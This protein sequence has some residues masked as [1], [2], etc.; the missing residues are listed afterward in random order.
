MQQHKCRT[1]PFGGEEA[2]ALPPER[3][4]EIMRYLV[5]LESSHLCHSSNNTLICRGGR[6]IQLRVLTALKL[7]K[8]PTDEEFDRVS[9]EV[10][11]EKF[12]ND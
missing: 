9:R 5:N 10:L 1:C 6:E 11:G 2:I 7:L 8:E 4:A 12:F 3:Y